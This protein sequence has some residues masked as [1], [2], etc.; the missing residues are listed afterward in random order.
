MKNIRILASILLVI[1]TSCKV[2]VRPLPSEPGKWFFSTVSRKFD[3]Q[4]G[5]MDEASG[6]VESRTIVRHLWVQ[7]DGGNI[8][9]L[10]LIDINGKFVKR[11]ALPF[12]NRDWE[13]LGIGPGPE[14]G[15]SYLYMADIGDNNARN[16]AC[17]IYRFPEPKSAGESVTT[18]DKITFKYPDG[19]RDAE[20]IL[21]DPATKDIF[22]VSK[23]ESKARLYKLPYPQSITETITA[24]YLGELPIF[25]PTGG[26][27]S[28]D[29][30]EILIRTYL[31]VNYWYRTDNQ[32]MENLLLNNTPKTLKID[33]EQQ[34]EAVAFSMARPGFYTLSEKRDVQPVTL[35]FYKRL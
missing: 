8:A 10:H 29:G 17:Y 25:G 19:A 24:K 31:D 6:M 32:S 23:R 4:A 35:N 30:S 20:T 22:I 2:P 11:I 14:T 27:V 7:E 18:V 1:A 26:S 9:Q 13:D 3:V 21:V 16:S 33:L 15:V 34:G 12:A 5:L 28:V